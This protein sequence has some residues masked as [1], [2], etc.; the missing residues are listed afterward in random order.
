M[1]ETIKQHSNLNHSTEVMNLFYEMNDIKI[2]TIKVLLTL[3]QLTYTLDIFFV[4]EVLLFHV[5]LK[6]LIEIKLSA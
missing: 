4:S 3:L 6:L 5:I 2:G 1:I